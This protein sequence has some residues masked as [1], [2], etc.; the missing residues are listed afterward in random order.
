MAI[1]IV[2]TLNRSLVLPL[3]STSG[4]YKFEVEAF[5]DN[6]SAASFD[7]FEVVPK[8]ETIPIEIELTILVLITLLSAGGIIIFKVAK[9]YKHKKEKEI[10]IN[11][12][13]SQLSSYIKRELTK[14]E[15][16][17]EESKRKKSKDLSKDSGERRR[18]CN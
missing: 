1:D 2:K 18:G 6:S 12:I 8:P 11:K 9:S 3:N 4:L 13:K 17:L 15:K 5:Y 7:A 16:R 14:Y 10:K